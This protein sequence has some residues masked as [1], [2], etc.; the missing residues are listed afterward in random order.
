MYLMLD[1]NDDAVLAV[2]VERRMTELNR[3][4]R[5]MKAEA[6]RRDLAAE[7]EALERVLHR[8]HEASYDVTC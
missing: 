1:R 8:L 5:R 6:D 3:A 2:A 4:L 7:L